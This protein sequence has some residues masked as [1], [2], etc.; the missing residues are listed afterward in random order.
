[1]EIVCAEATKSR[2]ET[3]SEWVDEYGGAVYKFCRSLAY[4]KQ[5]A[6]DLFQETFMKAFG[7]AHKIKATDNP[8]HFLFSITSHTWKSWKR[9]HAR[10]NRLAPVEPLTENIADGTSMAD[11]MVEQEEIRAVRALVEALPDK[12]GLP[13]TMY[14]TLEMRV[15]EIASALHIPPGTVKSRLFKAR[16]IIEKG[17]MKYGKS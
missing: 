12:Y 9:K 17:L 16:K 8:L 14:Y 4:S 10:R 13:I 3:V 5:D 7:Q 2:Q 6:D 11:D 1:M 15:P